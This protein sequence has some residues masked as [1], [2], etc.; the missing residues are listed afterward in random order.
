MRRRSGSSLMSTQRPRGRPPKFP[1]EEVRRRLLDAARESLKIDGVESGLDA[2]TLDGAIVDADVPRGMAYKIWQDDDQTPQDAFR[3]SVV[4]DLLSIPATAGL[5]ATRELTGT[6]FEEHRETFENGSVEDRRAL[7]REAMRLIGGFNYNSLA[8]SG[9]W[10][11]YAAL[12]TAAVTRPKVDP[13]LMNVL[14]AG[15]QY[16]IEQYCNLYQDILTVFNL[17]LRDGLTLELFAAAAYAL[18]EGLAQRVTESPSRTGLMLN[19]PQGTSKEWTLFSIAFEGIV[20]RFFEFVDSDGQTHRI[21][22]G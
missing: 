17:R 19:D 13:A 6:Y 10:K 9:N 18:N 5:P 14:L 22:P 15:E 8:D 7:M 20:D 16:L 12:R 2:V 21:L 11:L 4:V 3:R 1:P